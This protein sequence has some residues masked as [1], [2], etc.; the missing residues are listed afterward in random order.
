MM[1]RS[2]WDRDSDGHA[3]VNDTHPLDGTLWNDQNGNS[4][5]DE[6]EII[7]ADS[8][9]DGTMDF[10]DS[11]PHN[12]AL[13]S[14]WNQNQTNDELDPL[15]LDSDGDGYR[16]TIDT[17]PLN[18]WLWNDWNHDGINDEQQSPPDSDLDGTS[19]AADSF[20]FDF[21]NDSLPDAEESIWLTDVGRPDTDGDGLDDGC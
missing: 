7:R 11:H 2:A 8:D 4:V 1:P 6:D 3:D 14:D 19:D 5:N 21:D 13:W 10:R 20:P 12:A 18:T 15:D 16:D 9:A 17:D